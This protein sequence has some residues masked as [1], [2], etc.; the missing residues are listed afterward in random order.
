MAAISGQTTVAAAGT[1]VVLAAA[2]TRANGPVAVRALSGNTGVIYIGNAG[3]GTVSSSSGYQLAQGDQIIF[4]YVGD[5]SSIM[6]DAATNGDK[7][8]WLILGVM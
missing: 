1:E 6:V 8:S 7:V 3:D 5:L 4:A 2:G